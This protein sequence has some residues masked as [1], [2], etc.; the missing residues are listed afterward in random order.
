MI[1]FERGDEEIQGWHAEGQSRLNEMLGSFEITER[2]QKLY[3]LATRYH[4][5]TEAY[6]K[7]VC[8]GPM[9]DD[10]IMPATP[11]EMALI[12]RNAIAVRKQIEIEASHE[13]FTR[14][15]LKRAISKLNV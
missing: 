13:G 11:H 15:E 14:A 5:E 6:D 10:S 1:N 8:T 9:R 12:N 4:T 2:D 3:E 7:T